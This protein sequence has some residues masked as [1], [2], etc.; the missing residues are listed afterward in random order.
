[1]GWPPGG[2][3][4]VKIVVQYTRAQAVTWCGHLDDAHDHA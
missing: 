2:D 3:R 4:S 1:M